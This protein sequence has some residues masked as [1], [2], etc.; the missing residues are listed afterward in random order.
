MRLLLVPVADRPECRVA[1]DAAFGL[2]TA[3]RADV[4]GY[5]IRPEHR[6]QEVALGPLLPDDDVHAA[7]AA[8]DPKTPARLTAAREL[9]RRAIDRHGFTAADRPARGVRLQAFWHE[10]AGTPAR[11][12]AVFGP[13]A[14]L[15]VVSR[16]AT[17]GASRARAFL[18]GAL[19]H[20]AK[21]VLVLP[22]TTPA[23]LAQRIVVA[24]DQSA[25]AASAV[26][27]ALPLLTR[28]QRV[29]VVS[30]GRSQRLGPK[31]AHLARYLAHWDVAVERVRTP[32][33]RVEQ[34]LERTCRELRADLMVMG[35]YSRSRMRQLVLGGVTEHMLFK[36]DLPVLMLHR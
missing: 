3:L 31:V 22:Q 21:P 17:E 36:S 7:F 4:A 32:G 10:V 8:A 34:E 12:F 1:L 14:D 35:A 13:V 33:G 5:H 19:L 26:T 20:S 11:V 25:D 18:L 24:W 9:Y 27:A 28:A 29:I 30:A 16:P 6:E 23:T 2:A 15:T